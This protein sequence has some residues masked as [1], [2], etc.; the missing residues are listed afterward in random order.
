MPEVSYVGALMDLYSPIIPQEGEVQVP[1]FQIPASG[2][3]HAARVYQCHV[4]TL[5]YTTDNTI[6]ETLCHV[7][8]HY[9]DNIV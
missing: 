1:L 7:P 9:L 8:E 2:A 6:Q 3:V 5:L 4:Y